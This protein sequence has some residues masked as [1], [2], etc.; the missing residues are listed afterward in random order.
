MDNTKDDVAMWTDHNENF[1]TFNTS[2]PSHRGGYCTLTT[3]ASHAVPPKVSLARP[4]DERELIHKSGDGSDPDALR[5]SFGLYRA[6]DATLAQN[7]ERTNQPLTM[8]VLAIGGAESWGEAVGNVAA[9][10]VQTVVIPDTGHWVAEQAP[11][12]MLAALS[13]FLAPYREGG[14]GL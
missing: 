14:G 6:L 11:E 10:D 1:H 9:N 2:I 3:R 13:V 12:E 5:G 8:P 7:K 4:V